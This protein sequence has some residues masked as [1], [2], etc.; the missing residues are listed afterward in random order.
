[1]RTKC[2]E[3]PQR[4]NVQRVLAKCCNHQVIA[5]RTQLAGTYAHNRTVAHATNLQWACLHWY[6][7][8]MSLKLIGR[9]KKG[10]ECTFCDECLE[11]AWKIQAMPLERHFFVQ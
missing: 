9:K 5:T 4:S 8:C 10:L 2:W 1:M 3:P 7:A 6:F 11:N